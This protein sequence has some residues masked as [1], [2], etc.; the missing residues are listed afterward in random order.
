MH[1]PPK[2]RKSPSRPGRAHSQIEC[3]H[4][5]LPAAYGAPRIA[6]DLV[7]RQVC[8]LRFYGLP[9]AT[10]RTI[11]SLAFDGGHRR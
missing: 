11:A 10:A 8:A 4:K 7:A 1:A 2:K 3:F 5:Q 9:P 6:D